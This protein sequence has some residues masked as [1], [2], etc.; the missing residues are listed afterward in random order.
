MSLNDLKSL[1]LH[2]RMQLMEALWDTFVHEENLQSPA[3]HKK[4]LET[5]MR[6]MEER[7]VKSYSLDELKKE[8]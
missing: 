2:K 8:R 5:R 7:E 3:W 6:I 1:P 4:I